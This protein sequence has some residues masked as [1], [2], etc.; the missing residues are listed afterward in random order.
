MLATLD[1]LQRGDVSFET[2]AEA[3][4]RI[5][6]WKAS[7]DLRRGCTRELEHAF[8]EALRK[9]VAADLDAEASDRTRTLKQQSER[10]NK[11]VTMMETISGL[12]GGMGELIA[13]ARAKA[14]DIG[15][16]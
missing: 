9:H 1:S 14:K 3:G 2:V 8:T 10:L 4:G 13:R 5:S 6:A 12:G 16:Q 7:A 11:M 15:A